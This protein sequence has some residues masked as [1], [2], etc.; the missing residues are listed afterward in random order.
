M[1]CNPGQHNEG[2]AASESIAVNWGVAAREYCSEWGCG[3]KRVRIAVNGGVAWQKV[4]K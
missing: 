4:K 2:V 1:W 3:S